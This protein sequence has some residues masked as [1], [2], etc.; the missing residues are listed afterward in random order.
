M[1]RILMI[2][3][4]LLFIIC[5]ISCNEERE[6]NEEHKENQLNNLKIAAEEDLIKYIELLD[7]DNYTEENW[8]MIQEL[9]R[10]KIVLIYNQEN[11]NDIE[12][13]KKSTILEIE[14]IE[15]KEKIEEW[16]TKNFDINDEKWLWKGNINEEFTDDVIIVTLKKTKTYPELD[17]SCFDLDNATHIKYVGGV[18]PPEYFFKPEYKESLENFRQIVYIY[19]EPMGK[20]K[21]V[22]SIKK[23]ELLVF[24]RSVSPNYIAVGV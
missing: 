23:L 2:I 16:I 5:S 7:E 20:E 8:R 11:E 13:V 1:K 4:S 3:I 9:V 19:L 22:E 17:L 24:V 14:N 15:T 10:N 21:V 18:T 6:A 12:I